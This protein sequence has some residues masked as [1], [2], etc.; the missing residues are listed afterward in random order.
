M[1]GIADVSI[2]M[3]HKL[4]L[5]RENTGIA[6]FVDAYVVLPRVANS[7]NISAPNRVG[8]GD[9]LAV[10]EMSDIGIDKASKTSK[11]PVG[12]GPGTACASL[13]QKRLHEE[14]AAWGSRFSVIYGRG[15]DSYDHVRSHHFRELASMFVARDSRASSKTDN[16][17]LS[18][19]GSALFITPKHG[20]KLEITTH[21]E[22]LALCSATWC[23]LNRHRHHHYP[24][25]KVTHAA[26]LEIGDRC[27]P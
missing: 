10:K 3:S 25:I 26:N 22:R 4:A 9:V 8:S 23:I 24:V 1:V 21:A 17:R 13:A 12:F 18:P 5:Q 2:L 20:S 16:R 7:S 14:V 15:K 19:T 6:H 11:Q 27:V